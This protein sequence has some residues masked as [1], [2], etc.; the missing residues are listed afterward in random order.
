M[1][2][3]AGPGAH[4][5]GYK[6]GEHIGNALPNHEVSAASVRAL[7]PAD[8]GGFKGAMGTVGEPAVQAERYGR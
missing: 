5:V 6:Q 4:T 7:R 3:F 1:I 2:S 8:K